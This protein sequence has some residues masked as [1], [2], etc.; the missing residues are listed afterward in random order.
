MNLSI[1]SL[2]LHFLSISS[3]S[4][5]F[6]FIFS[7]FS[8][9]Q[10]A[11]MPQLVQPCS[12]VINWHYSLK[13]QLAFNRRWQGA[14]N[15]FCKHKVLLLPGTPYVG[16]FNILFSLHREIQV[17]ILTNLCKNLR[18]IHLT[19][20]TNPAIWTKFKRGVT[21]GETYKAWHWSDLGPMKRKLAWSRST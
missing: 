17:S 12:L 5:P 1:S 4:L 15:V 16:L 13:Q 20:L 10:D 8:R 21:Y 2:S 18:E 14:S 19:T 6:L 9:S 3:F 7:P 11:R